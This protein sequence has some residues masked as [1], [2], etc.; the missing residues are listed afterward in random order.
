LPLWFNSYAS[1]LKTII[2]LF[3]LWQ[4]E[5]ALKCVS[6]ERLENGTQEFLKEAGLMQTIDHEHITRMYGVVLDKELSLMLVGV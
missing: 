3:W 5:V 4:V 2:K 6:R 1:K